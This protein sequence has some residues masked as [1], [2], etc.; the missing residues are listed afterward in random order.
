MATIE[1]V[2]EN[3]KQWPVQNKIGLMAVMIIGIA[4][5][6]LFITWAQRADYQVLYSNLSEEDAGRIIEELQS[7]RIPYQVIPSGT[8]LVASN[9]VYD[10]RL[11]LAS[12]GLP[13][14][15]G[16]G[17]EIFDN[18][19]F[20][21]SEF[22]QKLNY[23]RALEGELARTIRSLSAVEQSRVHLV[24]P[25]RTAFA[26]EEDR[27]EA[28][29]A[30]FV[31]LNKGRKLTKKEVNGI[32]HLVASSVEDLDPR[33]VTVIDNQG[34]LLTSPTDDSA[35][36]LSSTQ[37][38]YQQNFERS[39]SQKIVSILEP[40]VGKGKVMAKVTASFDFTRSERTEEI[41]DP[42]MVAVRSEQKRTEKVIS[43]MP[44]AGGIPGVASNL[45]GGTSIG[46]GTSQGQ[47][48]KQ[49]EVINYETSKTVR[50]IVES[51]VK[52]QRMTVAILIDGILKS[53]K[54]NIKEPDKYTIRSDEDIRYYEDI[55]KKAI[56]FSEDRGDEIS[57]K[58][59]PFAEIDTGEEPE[60]G[61][62]DYLPI[63]YSVLK[64][65][66]P[67]AVALIFYLIILKP[68]IKSLTKVPVRQVPAQPS[69]EEQ[70][71]LQPKE[72]PLE[73]QVVEWANN[74]PQRAAGLVKGWIEEG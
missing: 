15:G 17:F 72:I 49:D 28:S 32:V 56:G 73:K 69:Q 41:Y 18:T 20:T 71:Q 39:V 42:D 45:P 47:S 12:E 31:T 50:R 2:I 40:V 37:M 36:G 64:Y 1:N 29:A 5:L 62:N 58:V 65:I 52:L 3:F 10:L 34:N 11:E 48:Q 59:M 54:G 4:S 26:F 23:R 22:I 57:V 46:T 60:T 13:Q 7:R 43:G 66:I 61:I 70:I 21:T 25:D 8:I 16:V 67:L 53:E 27:P 74:N 30:V 24:I 9:R 63:V 35:L 38:E 33:N 55:V 14:G 51:P 19:K 68:I 44:V 6:V